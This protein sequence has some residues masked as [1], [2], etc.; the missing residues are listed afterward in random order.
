MDRPVCWSVLGWLA[1]TLA[2][3]LQLSE[4][5]FWK[6]KPLHLTADSSNTDKKIQHTVDDCSHMQSYNRY[7]FEIYQQFGSQ[8]SL[9][10]CN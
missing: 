9:S 1:T 7:V 6:Q 5:R 4:A 2:A 3:V 10:H 8:A